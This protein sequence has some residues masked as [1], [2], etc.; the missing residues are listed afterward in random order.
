MRCFAAAPGDLSKTV[1]VRDD[2]VTRNVGDETVLL[3][4]NEGR[5]FV[6]NDSAAEMLKALRRGGPISRALGELTAEFDAGRDELLRDLLSFI[7]LLS[8]YRLVTVADG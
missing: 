2:L 6:L 5:Y 8:S 7:D 1:A 3:Q 4:L